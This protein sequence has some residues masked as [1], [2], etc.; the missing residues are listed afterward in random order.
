MKRKDENEAAF[1]ALQEVLRR[2]A[3]RDGI[4][5]GPLP[6]SAKV[7]YRVEAGKKGGLRGGPARAK[8]L[9]AKRR[10]RIAKEAAQ[11]RWSG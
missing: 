3:E 8:R 9:S 6:E 5:R 10:K 4:P 7:S 1:S 11:K 2:D